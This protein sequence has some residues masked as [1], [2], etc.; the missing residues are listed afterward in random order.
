M[1][2]TLPTRKELSIMPL[3]QIFELWCSLST[4]QRAKFWSCLDTMPAL[5]RQLWDRMSPENQRAL[6]DYMVPQAVDEE[7]S[8]MDVWEHQFEEEW[9]MQTAMLDIEDVEDQWIALSENLDCLML[10][11]S[12]SEEELKPEALKPSKELQTSAELSEIED[13]DEEVFR[14]ENL[15]VTEELLVKQPPT[16]ADLYQILGIAPTEIQANEENER[17]VFHI[18]ISPSEVEIVVV[19]PGKFCPTCGRV[20]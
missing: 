15:S 3:R 5:Q 8:F 10:Q 16:L 4:P 18:E 14:F 17:Q 20:G 7:P 6:R 1:L 9:A 13:L 19:P 12:G 11:N 2:I